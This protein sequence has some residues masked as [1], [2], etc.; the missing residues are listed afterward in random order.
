MIQST[1]ILPTAGE[2]LFWPLPA[3]LLPSTSRSYTIQS[4]ILYG[5]V[6]KVTA[7]KYFVRVTNKRVDKMQERRSEVKNRGKGMEVRTE[8]KRERLQG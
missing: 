7:G 5:P 4:S 8:D 6:T 1:E 3:P 2:A